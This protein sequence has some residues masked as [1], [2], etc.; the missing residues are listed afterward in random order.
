[1]SRPR[2]GVVVGLD[3]SLTSSGMIAVPAD[4]GCDW[5]RCSWAT[6]GYSVK[7]SADERARLERLATIRR[8]VVSFCDTHRPVAVWILGYAYNKLLSRAHSAGELGGVVKLGLLEASHGV[9]VVVESRAR[10][11][12]GRAPRKDVK[13]WAT[14][15]LVSAGAPRDW[16]Q[17]VLDAFVAAN[18]GLSEQEDSGALILR[19][20][21]G[22]P[23]S[24]GAPSL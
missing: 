12:L 8:D 18:W 2:K 14:Q 4:W 24:E 16:P 20:Q 22:L 9:R 11:L 15:R 21:P 3:L 1:M 13:L 6:S 19:D 5:S 23:F 10:T 17:D 7:D